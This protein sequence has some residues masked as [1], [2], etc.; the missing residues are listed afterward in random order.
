MYPTYAELHGRTAI[1]TG[2]AGGIGS[3]VARAFAAQGI[4]MALWDIQNG[5]LKA[6]RHEL[7]GV[8]VLTQVVDVS[9]A[10]AVQSAANEAETELGGID[11]LVNVAGGNAGTR[12]SLLN[13]IPTA[14][15]DKVIGANLSSAFH[16]IQACSEPMRRRG[17]GAVVNVASLASITMSL[18]FGVSYTAAKAGLLGLTRHAAMDLSRLGI[19]V[20]AVLPGPVITEVM[21]S[22][23]SRSSLIDTVPRQV[24]LG[25]WVEV[26]DVANAILFLCSQASAASTGSHLIVDCGLHIG[27]PAP[28]EIYFAQRQRSPA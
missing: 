7:S 25:R 19:R 8:Q 2:A 21:R 26:E 18:H 15:W 11:L 14:D 10:A 16:C 6:L 1:I 20:N 9:D 13:D 23:A 17:G 5:P 24:P 3:G 28:P 27:S 12:P 4:S 22:H